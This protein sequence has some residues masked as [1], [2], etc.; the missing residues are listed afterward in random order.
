ML[1]RRDVFS[2]RC[3]GNNGTFHPDMQGDGW[4][5]ESSNGTG[6]QQLRT[7]ARRGYARSCPAEQQVPTSTLQLTWRAPLGHEF[8]RFRDG[9]GDGFASG[10]APGE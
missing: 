6:F 8:Q 3:S 1:S 2:R 5:P 7:T 10:A 9:H 4:S